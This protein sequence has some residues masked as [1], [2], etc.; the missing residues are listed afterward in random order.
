MLQLFH[1]YIEN[2]YCFIDELMSAVEWKD[3]IIWVYIIPTLQTFLFSQILLCCSGNGHYDSV[4]TK[5][6]QENAAICQGK[7][8]IIFLWERIVCFHM[9]R[10]KVCLNFQGWGEE[11][12]KLTVCF[13]A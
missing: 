12:W 10:G 1:I 4:Y 9:F 3:I 6:Y 11:R 13:Y 5:Q 2:I 8:E 7:L